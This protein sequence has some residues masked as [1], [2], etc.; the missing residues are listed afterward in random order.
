[1]IYYARVSQ[2]RTINEARELY[3]RQL[4]E[5][6]EQERSRIAMELHDSL[7]QSLVTVTGRR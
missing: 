3:T 7:G 1:M 2:L 6:Q 5:S 4:L